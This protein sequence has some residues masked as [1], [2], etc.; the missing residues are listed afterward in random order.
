MNMLSKI[1]YRHRARGEQGQSLLE[2]AVAL[3]LVLGVAFNLINIGYFWFMVLAL[4]A[5]P[6]QGVQYASQGGQASATVS[7]P[8]T[9]AIKDL[10]YGNLTNAIKGATTSNASV[11]VCTIAKG[12]T[13]T[14][15]TQ[16]A[17][18]DSFGPAFGFSAITA[19]P[20]A[21]VFGLNRVDVK[22]TVTPLIPGPAFNVV[23]PA[24]MQFRRRV[25]MRSLY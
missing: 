10:V 6:R 11:R 14:G 23:L 16:V 8:G 20:E 19:D 15:A 3:P 22:Y 12:V 24:N 21:P 2:T 25:S 4:S 5:A 18:C 13:G 1:R 9:A 7:P 17:Q